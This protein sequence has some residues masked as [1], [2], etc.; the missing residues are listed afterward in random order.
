MKILSFLVFFTLVSSTAFGAC[1]LQKSH[2]IAAVIKSDSGIEVWINTRKHWNSRK[3]LIDSYSEND[4]KL[5]DQIT[6]KVSLCNLAESTYEPCIAG[7]S[8]SKISNELKAVCVNVDPAFQR[9]AQAEIK[10]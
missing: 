10:E 9:W 4:A 2:L 3:S 7:R 8:I 6:D 1:N 5:V